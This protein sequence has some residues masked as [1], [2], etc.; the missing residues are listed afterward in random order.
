MP[1]RRSLVKKTG[2]EGLMRGS[3]PN[4]MN[5]T[6]E[7]RKDRNIRSLSGPS[8]EAGRKNLKDTD[9]VPRETGW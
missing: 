3:L 9:P 1:E 2:A 8:S 6:E 5:V 7:G 4:R